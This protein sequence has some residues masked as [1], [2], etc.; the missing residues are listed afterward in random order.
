[1]HLLPGRAGRSVADHE[2]S[3]RARTF[4][5]SLLHAVLH[6]HLVLVLVPPSLVALEAKLFQHRIE[7]QIAHRSDD[8]PFCD[9]L[10]IP[11]PSF[12]P[13]RPTREAGSVE[14]A[15]LPEMAGTLDNPLDACLEATI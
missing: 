13:V 5:L 6:L 10:D 12:D 4:L 8:L 14:G 1:M 2:R 9:Q 7:G 15:R 11:K 3:L